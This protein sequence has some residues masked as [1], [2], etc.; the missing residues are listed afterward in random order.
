MARSIEPIETPKFRHYLK[1][2]LSRRRN[3][4]VNTQLNFSIVDRFF[5]IALSVVNSLRIHAV[6]ASVIGLPVALMPTSCRHYRLPF[7]ANAG[8]AMCNPCTY[9]HLIHMGAVS[10]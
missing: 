10:R 4:R 9:I 6:I 7:P 2:A 8:R 5:M 3:N 1:F